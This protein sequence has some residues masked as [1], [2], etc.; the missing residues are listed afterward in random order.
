MIVVDTSVWI[1]Y[2]RKKEDYIAVFEESISQGKFTA[3]SFV[4]GELLQGCKTS[5]DAE[6]VL[7]LYRNLPHLN[8]A[9][10][11]LDAGSVSQKEKWFSKGVGLIDAALIVTARRAKAKIWSLDQKLNSVLKPAEIYEP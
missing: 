3:T 8:E 1:E 10:V 9:E 5:A 2:L 11:W 6:R 7:D 4:F